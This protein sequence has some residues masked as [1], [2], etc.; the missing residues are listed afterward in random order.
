MRR[1]SKVIARLKETEELIKLDNIYIKLIEEYVAACIIVDEN[2]EIIHISGNANKYLMIPKG[3]PSHNL[4]KMLPGI[5]SVPVGTAINKAR[6]EQKEVVLKYIHFIPDA[7]PESM[8]LIVKPFGIHGENDKLTIIFFQKIEDTLQATIEELETSNEEFQASNEELQS[9]NEKL[10]SFNEELM[11][12]NS[13]Y[14]AKIQELSELNNDMTNFF[15]SADITEIK[16]KNAELTVLAYAIQQS[17]GSIAITDKDRNIKY[18]NTKY[19]EQTGLALEEVIHSKLELYSDQLSSEQLIDV[20]KEV[21]SGKKWMGELQNKYRN[22]EK[23]YEMVTLL[24]ITNLKGEITHFLKT[25]EDI[26][27][28]KHT[29]ELLHKSEMLSAVGQLAAGVAHE[30]RN[31][32]TALKGFTKLLEPV[33]EKKHYIEIMSSELERIE[34]IINELLILAKPQK[35]H[36]EK[37]DVLHILKDVIMLLE[38]QALLNNVDILTQFTTFVPIVNCIPNQL[39]QA[40]VNIFKN[41]IEAMPRGGDL[42]IKVNLLEK[43][44]IIV[45]FIDQGVGIPQHKIPKL[46]DP[47]YSTKEN[48]TGLGLMVSYK[49]IENHKGKINIKSVLGKGTTVEIIFNI[50]NEREING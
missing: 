20:W 41:A 33:T 28:Q 45:S 2:N 17:P 26:M 10:Q 15:V 14:Q 32:L 31:P 38:P 44:R 40:F 8:N 49:I 25:S 48:G 24:P 9:T 50:A 22:G 3:K 29:L 11:A 47:F 23:F 46:G 6:K 5:L 27:E 39:K 37:Q 21:A 35:L 1:N 18:I 34:M 16:K 12:A 36:Y 30:I 43:K 42:I 13:K 7:I 19:T 4:F